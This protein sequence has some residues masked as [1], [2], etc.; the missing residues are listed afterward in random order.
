MT[1]LKSASKFFFE[2]KKKNAVHRLSVGGSKI[3]D[4]R[5]SRSQKSID[6]WGKNG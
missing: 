4:L 6:F 3:I 5:Y 1:S 2:K